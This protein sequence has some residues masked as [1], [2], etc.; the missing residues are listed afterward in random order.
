MCYWVFDLRGAVSKCDLSEEWK[1]RVE[2]ELGQAR[3]GR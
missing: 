2:K 3:N 1:G